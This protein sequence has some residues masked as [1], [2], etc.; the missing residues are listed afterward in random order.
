MLYIPHLLFCTF[1]AHWLCIENYLLPARSVKYWCPT[2]SNTLHNSPNACCKEGLK[3][4]KC[5]LSTL[6]IGNDITGSLSL[7]KK[8]KGLQFTAPM[9]TLAFIIALRSFI[10]TFGSNCCMCYLCKQTSLVPWNDP[11]I[12]MKSHYNWAAY[13]QHI[14]VHMQLT[15][16]L[17]KKPLLKEISCGWN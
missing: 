6:V 2:E 11:F 5:N 9:D 15:A 3:S 8:G 17:H 14:S 13:E 4:S 7:L 16:V 12:V 10:L 1:F